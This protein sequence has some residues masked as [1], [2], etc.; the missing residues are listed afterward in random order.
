MGWGA[1]MALWQRELIRLFKEKSRW[2]GVVAQPLMVWVL[3]GLGMKGVFKFGDG[4]QGVS[5]LTYFFPGIYVMTLLFTGIFT[6]I[7]IIEDKQQG[8]M[9]AL[10]V[11]PAPRGA[12][13]LGKMAGATTVGLIQ[14]ALLLAFLPLAG[15]Y[16]GSVNWGGLFWVSVLGMAGIS[17]FGFGAAWLFDSVQGFHAVM[18]VLMFPM[19]ILSGAVFPIPEHGL[20]Y[21]MLV[22]P[23][24]YLVSGLRVALGGSDPHLPLNLCVWVLMGFS[25]VAIGGAWMGTRKSE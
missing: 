6:S 8:L 20:K 18:G 13:L 14:V 4:G 22:N 2:L 16:V 3:L 19:W 1:G 9:R 17:A 25:A 23:L 5:Y 24:T 10:L 7:S 12:I 21:V 15:Y 11:S